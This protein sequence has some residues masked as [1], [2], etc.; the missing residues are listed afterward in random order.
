FLSKAQCEA[1]GGACPRVCLDAVADVECATECYDGCYCSP[2]FYLLNNTCVP[3]Q[4]CP[5][6]HK[7]VL[8]MQGDSVPNDSCNN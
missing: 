8:Y 5:C 2:G 6:Y 3:L 1:Q 7:G 4:R